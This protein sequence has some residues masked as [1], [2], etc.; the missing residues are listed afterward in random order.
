M[1]LQSTPE[2]L[3][4]IE[5]P[6]EGF[7]R[8]A[9]SM[10]SASS[11]GP[12]RSNRLRLLADSLVL[13]IPHRRPMPGDWEGWLRFFL[14]GGFKSPG[15]QARLR[16][17]S[18]SSASPPGTGHRAGPRGRRPAAALDAFPPMIDLNPAARPSAPPTPPP[19]DSSPGWRSWK[20]LERDGRPPATSRKSAHF[21]RRLSPASEEEARSLR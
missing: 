14:R 5:V 12:P 1:R 13:P 17:S 4:Q 11:P 8:Q 16:A 7:T 20:N 21:D 9:R 10:P 15:E 3:Q 6:L 18:S 19:V 2:R